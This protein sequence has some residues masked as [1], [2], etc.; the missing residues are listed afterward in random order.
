MHIVNKT[1]NAEDR[2]IR[3]KACFITQAFTEKDSAVFPCSIHYMGKKGRDKCHRNHH[4]LVPEIL[5]NVVFKHRAYKK[6]KN[7]GVISGSLFIPLNE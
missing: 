3:R 6:K 4:I 1:P 2:Q 7:P 5:S